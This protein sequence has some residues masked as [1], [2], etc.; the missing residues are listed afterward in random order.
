MRKLLRKYAEKC[1]AGLVLTVRC[2][3]VLPESIQTGNWVRDDKG[4]SPCNLVQTTY[5]NN[6]VDARIGPMNTTVLEQSSAD[7]FGGH[8][9]LGSE[10]NWKD[11]SGEHVDV[12]Y[13]TFLRESKQKYVSGILYLNPKLTFDQAVSQV[14]ERVTQNVKKGNYLDNSGYLLTPAQ[15]LEYRNATLTMDQSVKLITTNL[16][17]KNVLVGI[18]E[19]MSESLEMLQRVVDSD[20]E[21]DSMFESF[22][23]VSPGA[24]KAKE[25][26]ANK[27]HLSSEEVLKEVEKD[28]D[29]MK[30]FREY[31]KYDEIVYRFAFEMHMRQYE[32][33]FQKQSTITS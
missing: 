20:G 23:K 30:V 17:E 1:N 19:R 29:F 14:K 10:Y 33:A 6:T 9:T 18:V 4:S 31:V 13:L 8:I 28:E 11:R 2:A 22:G 16:K 3:P 24:N 25:I 21:L 26:R 27:S 12:Q 32:S 15:R 5:R 7:I